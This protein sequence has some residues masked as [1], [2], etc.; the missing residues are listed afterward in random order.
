MTIWGGVAQSF[1][2]G[3]SAPGVDAAKSAC[4]WQGVAAVGARRAI[5]LPCMG[6]LRPPT[7]LEGAD[8]ATSPLWCFVARRTWG[9]ALGETSRGAFP[10][11]GL[12]PCNDL[13]G[14]CW[15]GIRTRDNRYL[16]PTL[17]PAELSSGGRTG[18]EPV[19]NG[20][21]RCS[22]SEL[23][24]ALETSSPA[25]RHTPRQRRAHRT[26]VAFKPPTRTAGKHL[27]VL[28]IDVSLETPIR[29]RSHPPTTRA[30]AS[31]HGAKAPL[32]A[33]PC[34][35]H[36][37]PDASGR[38]MQSRFSQYLILG[39]RKKKRPRVAT[40]GRSR[41]PREIGV[42]DLRGWDQSSGM[43]SLRARSSRSRPHAAVPWL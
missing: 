12:R 24:S 21:H 5:S 31:R 18:I 26:G 14:R 3:G 9:A 25:P 19:A 32:A 27:S 20:L 33:L 10:V 41:W 23:P 11:V 13:T 36:E 38:A 30:E 42:T 34:F 6:V 39:K 2:I 40:R 37:G 28:R 1:Q 35:G 29:V 7:R 4:S 16:K 15:S 8:P 17:Y 43:Q 22:A